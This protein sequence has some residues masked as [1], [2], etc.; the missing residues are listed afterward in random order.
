MPRAGKNNLLPHHKDFK[1]RSFDKEIYDIRLAY[2]PEV[3]VNP[4][5]KEY[6]FI[7]AREKIHVDKEYGNV[8]LIR[9][10]EA[11]VPF[12]IKERKTAEID[13]ELF[14]REIISIVYSPWYEILPT[15]FEAAVFEKE[16]NIVE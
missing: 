15:E 8:R 7:E 5:D 9:R 2:P 16:I 4:K 14:F 6:R 13:G 11:R 12:Q 10:A 3:E 1:S